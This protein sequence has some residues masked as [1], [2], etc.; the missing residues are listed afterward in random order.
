MNRYALDLPCPNRLGLEVSENLKYI[1]VPSRASK[2]QVFID[3]PD[4]DLNLGLLRESISL[5]QVTHTGGP[6]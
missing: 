6:G 1:A 2:L 5:C 4:R 3:W